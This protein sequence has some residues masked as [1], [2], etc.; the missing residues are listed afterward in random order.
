MPDPFNFVKVKFMNK[1]IYLFFFK[2][3]SPGPVVELNRYRNLGV[4]TV[5][6]CDEVLQNFNTLPDL[7]KLLAILVYIS[8]DD[9]SHFIFELIDD[10]QNHKIKVIGS[11]KKQQ[12][13]S[14]DSLKKL[15]SDPEKHK[16]MIDNLS[17]ELFHK[18]IKVSEDV[19]QRY[20]NLIT[21]KKNDYVFDLDSDT[22]TLGNVKFAKSEKDGFTIEQEIE[23]NIYSIYVLVDILKSE[24]QQLEKDKKFAVCQEC[25]PKMAVIKKLE[26]QLERLINLRQY[27]KPTLAAV[28]PFRHKKSR[29]R[30]S[31]SVKRRRKLRSKSKSRKLSPKIFRR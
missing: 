11:K 31:K 25:V 19:Y 12:R 3:E 22:R 30:G 6:N 18:K 16:F 23:I 9:I 8:I 4:Q 15:N 24:V 1:E 5:Q 28:L 26:L 20:T 21:E 2:V 7:I 17:P 29:R 14:I 27:Y 13:M 10:K